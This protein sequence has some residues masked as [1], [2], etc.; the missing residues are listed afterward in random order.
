MDW[1]FE[2][3]GESVKSTWSEIIREIQQDGQAASEGP[4]GSVVII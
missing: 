4:L 2:E 1:R 3:G